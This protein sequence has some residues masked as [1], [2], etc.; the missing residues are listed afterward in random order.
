MTGGVDRLLQQVERELPTDWEAWPGGWPGE[1][2]VALLD[3]VFSIRARYSGVR[4]VIDRWRE[5]RGPG[6]LDA[7]QELAAYV[8]RP[9]DLVEVLGSRQRVPG[10]S[11]TKA[12]AV[13]NAAR[14][15]VDGGVVSSRAFDPRDPDQRRAYV[16]VAGLGDVTWT[17]L[18]MLLGTPGVKADTMIRRFVSRSQGRDVGA[19][20]ARRLVGGAADRLGCDPIALDHAVWAHERSQRG[21]NGARR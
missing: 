19:D 15:L 11:A 1:I 13:A 17:Y 3:A 6:P 12:A 10:G 18:G 14:R 8:E 5:H 16:G 7:L 9:D 21:G 2:E 20:E 4:R